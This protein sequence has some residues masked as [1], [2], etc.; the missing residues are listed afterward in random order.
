MGGHLLE[1]GMRTLAEVRASVVHHHPLD[2][3]FAMQFD[4]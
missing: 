4:R 3:I 2:L 1:G